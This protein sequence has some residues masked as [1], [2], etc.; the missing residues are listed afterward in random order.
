MEH[1]WLCD[2]S[3]HNTFDPEGP[4]SLGALYD[5]QVKQGLL[6]VFFYDGAPDR[7]EFIRIFS[8][9]ERWTYA[10]FAVDGRPLVL[11]AVRGI[12]GKSG[13]FDFCYFTAGLP[14][15][16][17]LAREC[18]LMLREGGMRSLVGLTPA[19]Y[20]HALRFASRVGFARAG[21]VPGACVFASRGGRVADG[22]VTIM[23][24]QTL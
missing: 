20:R 1:F 12:T 19:P 6:E 18:L 3:G 10:A 13:M 21:V 17:R 5:A 23:D 7:E 15:K 8:G 11:A 22:V 9:E 2:V 14:C 24:L 16:E 4:L